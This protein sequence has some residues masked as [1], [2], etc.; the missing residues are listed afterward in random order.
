MSFWTDVIVPAQQGYQGLQQ[1]LNNM[2]MQND[3]NILARQ[4]ANAA[5]LQVQ[6]NLEMMKKFGGIK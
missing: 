2:V 1:D 4:Q 6:A 3:M 5:C